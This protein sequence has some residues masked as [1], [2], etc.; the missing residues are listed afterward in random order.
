MA[1]PA[2]RPASAR[3]RP[4]R[5]PRRRASGGPASASGARAGACSAARARGRACGGP[6]ACGGGPASRGPG[7]PVRAGASHPDA[8]PGSGSGGR[9]GEAQ[10]DSDAAAF[11]RLD[12]RAGICFGVPIAGGRGEEGRQDVVVI[13]GVAA[14]VLGGCGLVLP[15]GPGEEHE[16]GDVDGECDC[17][18]LRL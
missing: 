17:F 3:F 14:V 16:S 12:R 7:P 9:C 1:A 15:D 6:R 5:V 10:D 18:K 8:G 11:A 2:M 4:R 13:L